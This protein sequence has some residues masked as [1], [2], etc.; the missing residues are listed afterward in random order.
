MKILLLIIATFLVQGCA[1]QY[2]SFHKMDKDLP[3][4]GPFYGSMPYDEKVKSDCNA[5]A[6]SGPYA[7]RIHF[8]DTGEERTYICSEYPKYQ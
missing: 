4:R 5:L 3:W 1:S 6:F 8:E 7:V 2:H